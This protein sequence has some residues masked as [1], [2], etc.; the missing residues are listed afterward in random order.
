MQLTREPP[1]AEAL[2]AGVITEARARQRRHR[3]IAAVVLAA[4]IAALVLGFAGGGG[5]AHGA[6][7]HLRP[8]RAPGTGSRTSIAACLSRPRGGALHGKPSDSLLSILGV[9]RRRATPSDALPAKA[10]FFLLDRNFGGAEVYVNYIRRARVIDGVSYYVYPQLEDLCGRTSQP[11]A[12]LLQ[13]GGGSGTSWGGMGTAA[14]IQQG[15]QGGTTGSFTH[16]T[17][18]MLIPDGV[19]TVTLHYPA[20]IVGGFNRHHA[21]A[22]TI[23]TNVVGNLIVVTVPRDGNREAEPDPMIWRAANGRIVLTR[24]CT[25]ASGPSPPVCTT[26]A[27]RARPPSTAVASGLSDCERQN[28]PRAP[29][30][31]LAQCPRP[32]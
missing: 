13:W 22:V 15:S 26:T 25:Q 12:G 31:R 29:L 21:R 19:T 2:D 14:T 10:R 1:P 5:G 30:A 16:T 27:N 20:G 23:T 32:R 28:F 24:T 8:G 4:A 18:E 7:G 3:S 6:R 9:L 11:S 17:I